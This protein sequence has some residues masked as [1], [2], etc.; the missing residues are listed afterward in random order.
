MD[1]SLQLVYSEHRLTLFTL[2][3]ITTNTRTFDIESTTPNRRQSQSLFLNSDTIGSMGCS[4]TPQGRLPESPQ[5]V[6]AK[7]RIDSKTLIQVQFE[8]RL[9]EQ[10]VSGHIFVTLRSTRTCHHVTPSPSLS[11]TTALFMSCSLSPLNLILDGQFIQANVGVLRPNLTES[12]SEASILIQQTNRTKPLAW[13][14]RY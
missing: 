13:Q 12:M 11:R 14:T 10:T 1:S 5:P 2:R 7:I 4:R 9:A 8:P 3:E 6:A